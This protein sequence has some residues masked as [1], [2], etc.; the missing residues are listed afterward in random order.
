MI[1]TELVE[2]TLRALGPLTEEQRA[3]LRTPALVLVGDALEVLSHRIAKEDGYE[4]LQKD[5]P[6]TPAAG[7]VDLSAIAALIF[8]IARTRVRIASS[9]LPLYAVDSMETLAHGG[10]QTDKVVYAQDGAELR[11]RDTSGNLGTYVTPLKLKANYELTL[12]D[13]PAA[14]ES[15]LVQTLA[16]L[17]GNQLSELRGREMAANTRA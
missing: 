16:G 15:A 12:S 11:F 7:V 1:V 6:V 14:Y 13:I 17:V 8:D 10:L 5:F 9:N 4:G 3:A 2:R